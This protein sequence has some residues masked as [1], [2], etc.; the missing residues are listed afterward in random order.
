[1]RA[2]SKAYKSIALMTRNEILA[3]LGPLD[4]WY[5]SVKADLDRREKLRAVVR[6]GGEKKLIGWAEIDRKNATEPVQY[7][8]GG[9]EVS[10]SARADASRIVGV[11]KI[12]EAAGRIKFLA[13]VTPTLKAVRAMI[14]NADEQGFIVT[15]PNAGSREILSV[16]PRAA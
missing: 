14:P 13:E 11:E 12:W 7:I 2:Q 15:E 16:L 5:D 9:Y 6:G 1:M 10:L 3:E 8:G 4:A